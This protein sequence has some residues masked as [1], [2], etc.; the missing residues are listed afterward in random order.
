M[1]QSARIPDP[2][3]LLVADNMR[4]HRL[5]KGISQAEL[6]HR[7]GITAQQVQKYERGANR[8][9]CGRLVSVA[10]IIAVPLAAMFEGVKSEPVRSGLSPLHLIADPQSLRLAQ[11]YAQITKAGRRAVILALVES[12]ARLS[13]NA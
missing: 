5:A 12:L 2:V 7:L 4:I 9:S 13:D 8:I 6:A 1:S 3:D 11:A 10:E